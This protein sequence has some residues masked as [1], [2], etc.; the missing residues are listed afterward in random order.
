MSKELR[1]ESIAISNV[2]NITDL[3][4]KAGSVTV[5]SGRNGVGKSS[6]L[7]AIATVFEGGHDA[8]MIRRGAKAGSVTITL[9]DGVTIKKNI[10]LKG[11]TVKVTTQDGGL[12]KSPTTYVKSLTT[13]MGFDP[14]AFVEAKQK[15][16]LAFLLEAMP[17]EFTTEQLTEALKDR[18]PVRALDL[19]GFNGLLDGLMEERREVN[20]AGKELDG[21]IARIEQTLPEDGETD[22]AA[23]VSRI[24]GE[25]STSEQYIAAAEGDRDAWVAAEK[26]KAITE[27]HHK[28]NVLKDEIAKLENGRNEATREVER[29]GQRLYDESVAEAGESLATL[30]E[31][32]ATAKQKADEATRAGALREQLQQ[33]RDEAQVKQT[34]SDNLTGCID[35]MRKLKT[36]ILSDLPI[37]GV[38]IRDGEVYVSDTPWPHV[39][40]SEQYMVAAQVSSLK[41]S[42]LP[43]KILDRAEQLDEDRFN[44]LAEGYAEAGLQLVVARV[45][46]DGELGVEARP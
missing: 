17:I 36:D 32:A 5:I 12:V 19:D 31:E 40:T 3:E 41:A 22:W 25:L 4:F 11:T 1:I 29:E 38:D 15:D 44:A 30:R 13:G 43:F 33:F 7:D 28:I 14:I 9:S 2:K 37:D 18:A 6:V 24:Q 20:V 23:E 39:N 42:E 34:A 10:T 26:G 35:R 27:Y 46:E 8:N 45:T 16:R 21:T